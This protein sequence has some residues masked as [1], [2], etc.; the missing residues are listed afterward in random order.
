MVNKAWD[1]KKENY[2]YGELIYVDIKDLYI[3]E[4]LGTARFSNAK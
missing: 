4:I 2:G 1:D 3:W